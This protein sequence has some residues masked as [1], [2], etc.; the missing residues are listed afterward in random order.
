MRSFPFDW[1]EH[2]LFS[3]VCNLWELYSLYLQWF[4]PQWWVI[5]LTHVKDS[6]GPLCSSEEFCLSVSF[7]PIILL[8]KFKLSWLPLTLI[9]FSQL[10]KMT[11]LCLDSPSLFF[12]LETVSR[13]IN[14]G[15]HRAHLTCFYFFR[16]Y[17][18]PCYNSM[19]KNIVFMFC[20]VF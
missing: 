20:L 16:S 13:T 5:F 9:F 1:W 8:H 15:S 12:S 7:L 18:L 6:T 14:W 3:A 11:G 10:S 4:F 2:K 17:C 19:S